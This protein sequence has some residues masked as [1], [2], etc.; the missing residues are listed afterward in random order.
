MKKSILAIVLILVILIPF[1][2]VYSVNNK[3]DYNFTEDEIKWLED[4]KG[5]TF[6]LATESSGNEKYYYDNNVLKGSAIDIANFIENE[7]SININVVPFESISDFINSI[8]DENIDIYYGPFE[9]EDRK[10]HLNFINAKSFISYKLVTYSE[11]INSIYCLNRKTIGFLKNDYIIDEFKNLL[12]ENTDIKSF[13]QLDIRIKLYDSRF[14]LENSLL[15]NEVDA[16]IEAIISN[17][18]IK[19]EANIIELNQYNLPDGI[20]SVNKN[21]TMLYNIMNKIISSSRYNYDEISKNNKK[22]YYNYLFFNNLTLKELDWLN[23]TKTIYYT[24]PHLYEPL[25]FVK[26]D[27]ANGI[28][29]DYMEETCNALN[30]ELL[31]YNNEKNVVVLDLFNINN[32]T[33]DY[34]ITHESDQLSYFPFTLLVIGNKSTKTINSLHELENNSI[35][36]YKEDPLIH[37]ITKNYPSINIIL[38][39][40]VNMTFD[41]V[42]NGEIDYTINNKYIVDYYI[43]K[44]NYTNLY[45]SGYLTRTYGFVATS[46]NEIL[47]SILSKYIIINNLTEDVSS[48]YIESSSFNILLFLAFVIPLLIIITII[49]L[50]YIRLKKESDKLIKIEIEQ[51]EASKKFENILVSII[52]SLERATTYNDFETGQ[53]T[54]RISLYCEFLANELGYSENEVKEITNFSV[55]HDLGKIGIDQK[56]LK[57]PGRLTELEYSEIKKH[58]QIGY[59]MIKPLDLGEI[60]ENIIMYHHERWD[61]YGYLGLNGN[62]IPLESLIVGIADAYDAM[63]MKRVYKEPMSHIQVVA[64]IKNNNGLQ[65]APGLVNLFLINNNVFDE[66]YNNNK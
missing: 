52:E 61:G 44:R 5:N 16:I 50:F 35:A 2:L 37:F 40:S 38:Y 4:N 54:R 22:D 17:K 53:H 49:S 26:N 33:H 6:T 12:I 14:D 10:N 63:R 64:E 46:N 9:N 42:N 29:Y 7:L 20:I 25:F 1:T 58:V 27:E 28:I 19:F 24:A 8:K 31:P 30:I 15:N 47:N 45:Y 13:D 34:H 48:I 51:K 23:N 57:K 39:D 60:A 32:I 65:F 3:N 43:T 36:L 66:I 56:I 21:N 41:S 62:Q 11:S 55:L 18:V 59:D